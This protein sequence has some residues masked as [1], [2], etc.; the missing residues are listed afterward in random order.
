MGTDHGYKAHDDVQAPSGRNGR[1]IGGKS[2]A[3]KREKVVRHDA[4][5]GI[6]KTIACILI[7][8]FLFYVG[9]EESPAL[10][11]SMLWVIRIL[12]VFSM[13]FLVAGLVLLA[14]E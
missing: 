2:A 4:G 7:S 6:M 9:A 3:G 12:L 5:E 13:V 10:N 11:R 8:W 14:V 1:R